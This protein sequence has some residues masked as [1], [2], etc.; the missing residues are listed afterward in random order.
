MKDF[1]IKKA[2]IT[3]IIVVIA[4]AVIFFVYTK[5]KGTVSSAM[6]EKKQEF[7]NSLEISDSQL[8]HTEA[9]VM[10]FV[11]K[12]KTAMQG[13]GTNENAIYEVFEQMQT[14]DDVLYLI[15]KFGTVG[16][17]TLPEWIVSELS[18]KERQ[19]LNN[20]LEAQGIVYSF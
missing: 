12:L 7:I 18:A 8:T 11:S 1:D 16:G 20:I 19:H 4:I 2:A 5:I 3:T 6:T 15:S 13:A 14:R 9:Q 10:N 17:E